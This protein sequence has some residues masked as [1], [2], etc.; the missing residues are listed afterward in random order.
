MLHLQGIKCF[1]G[2]YSFGGASL[3]QEKNLFFIYNKM[4]SAKL[5][6]LLY[7]AIMEAIAYS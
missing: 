7:Q 3:T 1:E 5:W 2:F 4:C 6:L